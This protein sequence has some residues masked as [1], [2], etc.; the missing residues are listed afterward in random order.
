MWLWQAG[1]KSEA[2]AFSAGRNAVRRSSKCMGDQGLRTLEPAP[3]VRSGVGSPWA[4]EGICT[5]SRFGLGLLL[6]ALGSAACSSSGGA[7]KHDAGAG[8]TG[9]GE[10][11]VATDLPWRPDVGAND[12]VAGK[13]DGGTG[14]KSDGGAEAS[15]DSQRDNVRDASGGDRD[16]IADGADLARQKDLSGVDH[17][18]A[19]LDSAPPYDG[20]AMH[21]AFVAR[22]ATVGDA[23]SDGLALEQCQPPSPNIRPV[24]FGYLPVVSETFGPCQPPSEPDFPMYPYPMDTR[25]HA[26][27][28]AGMKL[29]LYNAISCVDAG[30]PTMETTTGVDRTQVLYALKSTSTSPRRQR[31]YIVSAENQQSQVH[32][33]YDIVYGSDPSSQPDAVDRMEFVCGI[34]SSLPMFD[35]WT[36]SVG[37]YLAVTGAV[38]FGAVFLGSSAAETTPRLVHYKNYCPTLSSCGPVPE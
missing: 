4:T 6:V 18:R 21:D 35:G 12:D 19:D 22:D 38:S 8:E 20:S 34:P 5:S 7:G 36:G 31:I 9:G 13:A 28:E 23:G 29:Y 25:W 16:G 27:L 14:A 30:D 15:L 1:K 3:L 11:E 24:L 33:A 37:D 26:E 32:A 2:G 17:G 10:S